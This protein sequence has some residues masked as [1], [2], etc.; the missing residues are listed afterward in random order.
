MKLPH[1]G[2]LTGFPV[3]GRPLHAPLCAPP[4]CYPQNHRVLGYVAI[5][6]I[7]PEIVRGGCS[8]T[9]LK[10]MP[11]S[12]PGRGILNRILCQYIRGQS[13]VALTRAVN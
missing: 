5:S 3:G 10:A 2:K 11:P 8:E 12:Q 13:S 6:G 4:I 1:K 9:A 7:E